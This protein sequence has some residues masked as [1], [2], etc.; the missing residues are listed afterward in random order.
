MCAPQ[1][2]SHFC[3]LK[4]SRCHSP[5]ELSL[6]MC[7]RGVSAFRNSKLVESPHKYSSFM[8]DDCQMLHFKWSFGN[9]KIAKFKILAILKH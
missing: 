2:S 7:P 4:S 1:S 3:D 9:L 5:K 8:E 6:Y